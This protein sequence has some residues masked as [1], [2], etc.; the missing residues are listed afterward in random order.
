MRLL[1]L[2]AGIRIAKI[3]FYALCDNTA[4][5]QILLKNLV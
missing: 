5:N 2:H 3:E 4:K 1:V